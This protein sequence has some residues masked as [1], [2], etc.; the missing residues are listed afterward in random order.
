MHN[1]SLYSKSYK[2]ALK[3][4]PLWGKIY[5]TTES[6]QSICPNSGSLYMEFTSIFSSVSD[7]DDVH[8]NKEKECI[9]TTLIYNNLK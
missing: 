5:W 7:C 2:Y 3:G 6:C 4:Y 8:V 9:K 1:N